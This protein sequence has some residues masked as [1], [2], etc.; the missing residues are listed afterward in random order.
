MFYFG[1]EKRREILEDQPCNKPQQHRE[2]ENQPNESETLRVLDRGMLLIPDCESGKGRSVLY[3]VIDS[4]IRSVFGS[5]PC[6]ASMFKGV[7]LCGASSPRPA[8]VV[9]R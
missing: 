6:L 3:P 8:V 1:M 4:L 7:F 9:L 2:W 5:V